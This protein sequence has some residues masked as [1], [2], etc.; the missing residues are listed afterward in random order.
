MQISKISTPLLVGLRSTKIT[1]QKIR[2]NLVCIAFSDESESLEIDVFFAGVGFEIQA[3]SDFQVEQFVKDVVD[4]EEKEY[5]RMVSE[6]F[7]DV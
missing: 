4:S 5:G 1:L 3:D 7:G 6:Y 2:K